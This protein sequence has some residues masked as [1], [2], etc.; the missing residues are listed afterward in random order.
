MEQGGVSRSP[1]LT[2]NWVEERATASLD[3]DPSI[4]DTV[5]EGQAHRHGHRGIISTQLLAEMAD[6]TTQEDSYRK[7]STDRRRHTGQREDMLRKYLY[8]KFSQEVLEVLRSPA[9]ELKV[10]ET[11]TKRDYHVD[12]FIPQ[13]P[14]TTKSHDYCTE[15]AVTFWTDNVRNIT[16][17]SDRRAEDSPFKKSSAFTTP[18]SHYLDQPVPHS[19]ENYP[20]M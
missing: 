14:P 12:G 3:R 13:T 6:S 2:G 1:G 15:E 7:P 11:T 5:G 17:V 18:I 16:G 8:Q 19:L 10:T 4:A 9:E 20:N